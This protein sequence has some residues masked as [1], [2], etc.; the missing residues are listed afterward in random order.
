MALGLTNRLQAQLEEEELLIGGGPPG[1]LGLSGVGR[2]VEFLDHRPPVQ[3]AVA[4]AQGGRQQGRDHPLVLLKGLADQSPQ[5]CLLDMLIHRVNGP[6]VVALL[7]GR[8]EE[9]VGGHLLA[10]SIP[11]PHHR[12]G[13]VDGQLFLQVG[14][15]EEGHHHHVVTNLKAEAE[16]VAA[17]AKPGQEGFGHHLP[18]QGDLL[19]VLGRLDV[20]RGQVIVAGRVV[21]Q[22]VGH[23]IDPQ[24]RQVGGPLGPDPLQLGNRI[25]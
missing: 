3:E 25:L 2:K 19:L 4:L 17:V 24:G 8:G 5:H 11:L 18:D 1:G 6:E 10:A 21:G 12:H 13:F 15:V 9:A 14:L 22:E 23:R 16:P 20:R 7:R